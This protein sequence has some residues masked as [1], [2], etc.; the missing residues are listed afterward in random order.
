MKNT[1]RLILATACVA[2][3][4]ACGG[5]AQSDVGSVASILSLS[6]APYKN[7][8]QVSSSSTFSI[9][10]NCSGTGTEN[11]GSSYATDLY[12]AT[13][14]KTTVRNFNYTNC[15][16]SGTSTSDTYY[17]TNF[18]TLANLSGD[19]IYTEATVINALPATVKVGDTITL[20]NFRMFLNSSKTMQLRTG[21]QSIEIEPD[22]SQSVI[23]NVVT[24]QYDSSNSISQTTQSRY[25]LN[26][27]GE[28]KEISFKIDIPSGYTETWT[29]N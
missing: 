22:T 24:Q 9:S 20:S 14:G 4:A 18:S 1:I 8:R 13:Y 29:Y 23:L 21:V 12:G 3:L 19:G 28:V 6:L 15:A 5:G 26:S 10:G 11:S 25:R 2:L 17:D 7:L 27:S 16:G